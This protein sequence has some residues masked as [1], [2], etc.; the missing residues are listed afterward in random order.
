MMPCPTEGST[1]LV[2]RAHTQNYRNHGSIS[3][4]RTI[5]KTHCKYREHLPTL[6]VLTSWNTVLSREGSFR[7]CDFAKRMPN[8]RVL[9]VYAH[10]D[11]KSFCH[12]I[13][14]QFTKGLE[15]AGHSNEIID[16][17]AIGFDPVVRSRDGPNW[18]DETVPVEMLDIMNLKQRVLDS[19][20]GPIQRFIVS[21]WLQN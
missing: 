2:V 8:M 20:G 6:D 12:A 16:L 18:I 7:I 10:P 9:T 21:R 19:S 14:Q 11:P 17:Y 13:L 5:G 1:G 3:V 15:D 4:P